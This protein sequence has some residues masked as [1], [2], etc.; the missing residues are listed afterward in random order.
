MPPRTEPR[1]GADAVTGTGI[2]AVLLAGGRGS[3]LGGVDKALLRRGAQTQI[4]RWIHELQVRDIAT[5]V[6]GPPELEPLIPGSVPLVREAP[7][8]A[9]PAAGVLA[10]AAALQRLMRY[11]EP[12]RTAGSASGEGADAVPAGWTLLL[13]VD[14]TEPAALLDWLLGELEQP[15]VESP[16][17]EKPIA[18]L[19][20]DASGRQQYLSSAVPTDWLFGRVAGL[21][22]SEPEDR[23][24]RWLLQG[25]EEAAR[26]RRPVVPPGVSEDVDTLHD[27]HRLGMRL[28]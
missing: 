1:S 3:R 7:R 6:V 22:P 24:L 26:L 15:D 27:A 12:A 4:E 23:P 14:L 17:V 16:D 10:G 25:L 2:S 18:V 11:P 28:P 20:S 13:A 5:V 9:G 19:P 8:F 21:S